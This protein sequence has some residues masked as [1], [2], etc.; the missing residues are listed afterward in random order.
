MPRYELTSFARQD[1]IEIA[2]YTAK[3]WGKAQ[4][5]RYAD[6][7]DACF[8]SIAKREKPARS[9]SPRYPEVFVCRCEHH[10]I[11]YLHPE[12]KPPRI[13]A[14]LHEKMDMLQRL[15]RRLPPT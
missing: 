6:A 8:V 11:F 15:S 5:L 7:L 3:T 14:V 13:L 1:L 9:V 12:H 2:E 4:A 10:Y